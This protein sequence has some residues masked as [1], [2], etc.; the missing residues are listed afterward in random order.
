M[1]SKYIDQFKKS[2]L[3]KPIC[4][5]PRVRICLLTIFGGFFLLLGCLIATQERNPI[6]VSV[7]I[8][9]FILLIPSL[10]YWFYLTIKCGQNGLINFSID[11]LYYS[12]YGIL[13]SWDDIGPAWVTGFKVSGIAENNVYFILLNVDK[14]RTQVPLIHK[15]FFN[16]GQR[17]FKSDNSKILERGLKYFVQYV[18]DKDGADALINAMD[19]MR[20]TVKYDDN[21]TIVTIPSILHLGTPREDIAFIINGS[22]SEERIR[23][24]DLE[25]KFEEI[26]LEPVWRRIFKAIC[27]HLVTA[28]T[29]GVVIWVI[30]M[31]DDWIAS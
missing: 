12:H 30:F 5:N 27:K 26:K 2:H 9:G 8:L 6:I 31:I 29:A 16:L 13:I 24:Y 3:S 22:I 17:W 21:T 7:G 28:A 25:H 11:G 20:Q 19:R 14:Y 15:F 18:D 10:L 1:K 4:I 23:R